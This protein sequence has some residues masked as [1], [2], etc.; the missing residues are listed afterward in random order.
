MASAA[1]QRFY[2]PLAPWLT[3][4]TRS[5]KGSQQTAPPHSAAGTTAKLSSLQCASGNNVAGVRVAGGGGQAPV[6]LPMASAAPELSASGMCSLASAA[7]AAATHHDLGRRPK[8]SRGLSSNAAPGGPTSA[9]AGTSAGT[10]GTEPAAPIKFISGVASVP[11]PGKGGRGEDAHFVSSNGL[12]LGVADG[13]GGW[14]ELG[15]DSG[16]FSRE[17]MEQCRRFHE[18]G[19]LDDPQAVLCKAFDSTTSI[20]TSTACL[21]TLHGDMLRAANVG[22]SSFILLRQPPSLGG[23]TAASASP[24]RMVQ[25]ADGPDGSGAGGGGTPSPAGAHGVPSSAGGDAGSDNGDADSGGG[26][27]AAENAMDMSGMSVD[28][29]EAGD[30]TWMSAARAVLGLDVGDESAAGSGT[31]TGVRGGL[32]WKLVYQAPEQQHYFNCPL[33]LGTNSRDRPEDAQTFTLP[34][35]PGDLVLAATDGLFD[36]LFLEE[37]RSSLVFGVQ[38]PS[39]IFCCAFIYKYVKLSPLTSLCAGRVSP[40]MR[41]KILMIL[42]A[43]SRRFLE[44]AWGTAPD[45]VARMA[46]VLEEKERNGERC[47]GVFDVLG[48]REVAQLLDGLAHKLT[49]AA[50]VAA[51]DPARRSPFAVNALKNGFRFEGGKLDDVTVIAAYVVPSRA[52]DDDG[53]D[54]L[55]Q[56]TN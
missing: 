11:H 52:N 5:L 40:L 2:G 19:G 56:G 27:D 17:L 28:A 55:M 44:V 48:E 25:C 33:Q 22:D 41:C 23:Q 51:Q 32:G 21:L 53:D 6:T 15:I 7:Q 16:K 14:A 20:G 42:R 29:A 49:Q 3:K 50:H 10:A 38:F 54:I 12:A 43:H 30:S 1:P 34:C 46:R 24:A 13:V 26:G 8:G 47:G 36:N 35:E 39:W 4:I 9:A 18:R 37:V 31:S 45:D